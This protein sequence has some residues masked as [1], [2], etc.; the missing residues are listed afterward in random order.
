M[1]GNGE[2]GV[3]FSPGKADDLKDKLIFSD[4]MN[5]SLERKKVLER[6]RTDHVGK[7]DITENDFRLPGSIEATMTQNRTS[8]AIII[9]GG[10][11]TGKGNLGVPVLERLVKLLSN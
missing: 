4:T 9:P 5:I 1:S 6:Y 3:L 2:C 11:G 7:S 8:I 10:I